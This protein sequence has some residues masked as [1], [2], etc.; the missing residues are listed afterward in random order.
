M[1]KTKRTPHVII[2][3]EE[4]K[5]CGLCIEACPFDVLYPSEKFNSH[6]YHPTV[7][8][9]EGCTGCG[10]CFYS[11][12]EPGAISIYKDWNTI[13]EVA[14]CNHCGAE[15]KVFYRESHPGVKFCTNC[16]EPITEETE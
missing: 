6:G 5:G 10:T 4:C 7:Y 2:R 12:P 16:Q 1:S 15:H 13:Q 11:C 3:W 9:G 14:N 8:K